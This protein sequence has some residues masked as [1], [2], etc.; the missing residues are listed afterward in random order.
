MI[1]K[2]RYNKKI[3]Y[4]IKA[5]KNKENNKLTGKGIVKDLDQVN[6]F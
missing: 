6:S 1:V 4:Q 3:I 5:R 2:D